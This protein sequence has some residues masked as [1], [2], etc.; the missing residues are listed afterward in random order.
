MTALLRVATEYIDGIGRESKARPM[1]INVDREKISI[2]WEQNDF[3]RLFPLASGGKYATAMV[4]NYRS[5]F[6]A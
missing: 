1:W 6:G 2:W 3:D 4:D 5:Q